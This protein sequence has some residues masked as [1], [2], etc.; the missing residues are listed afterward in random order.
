MRA[1]NRL[2]VLSRAEQIAL[3]ALPDFNDLQRNEYMILSKDEQLLALTRPTI[4][5]QIYCMLQI[6]YFKTKHS[7][8][9]F[10]WVNIPTE[11]VQFIVKHY[12]NEQIEQNYITK[13]EIYTQREQIMNFY[14]Y[15]YCSQKEEVFLSAYLSQIAKRGISIKFILSE[16]LYVS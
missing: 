15:K 4:S 14:G 8:F 10:A 12:F 1:H 13:H 16:L 11:D 7:F 5:A 2:T 9:K 6:A 3:Y